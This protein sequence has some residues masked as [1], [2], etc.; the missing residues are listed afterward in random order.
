MKRFLSLRVRL[1][2]FVFI[3][4]ALAAAVLVYARL[5]WLWPAFCVGL[6]A[7]AAAWLG[8]EMFI[9]RQVK[10]IHLTAHK[11]AEGD[12]SARTGLKNESSELGDLANSLD[13]MAET[14]KRQIAEGEHSQSAL[15]Q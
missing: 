14:L 12:F 13:V 8:G 3:A 6:F 9:L 5:E 15:L 2:G 4:V 1:V 10:S 11:L 7:L